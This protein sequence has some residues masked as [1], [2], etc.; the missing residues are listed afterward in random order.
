[1]RSFGNKALRLLRDK[2][3]GVN[4]TW[5][6]V[7][8]FVFLM[9]AA[10][11]MEFYR[12]YIVLRA[13]NDGIENAIITTAAQNAYNAFP[14]L[15]DGNSTLYTFSDTDWEEIFDVGDVRYQL[16]SKYGCVEE[17]TNLVQYDGTDTRFKIIDL[18]LA[19]SNPVR[20]TTG[21]PVSFTITATYQVELPMLFIGKYPL[22]ITLPQRQ[23]SEWKPHFR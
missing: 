17:D 10:V 22:N 1:M 14:G 9:I 11:M 19:V 12:G 13:V 7:W 3:G 16:C 8:I 4:Y 21:L 15:R 6:A 5:T 20:D 23:V 18:Q 2:T